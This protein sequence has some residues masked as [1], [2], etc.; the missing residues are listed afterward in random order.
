MTR[1]N[2]PTHWPVLGRRLIT[3]LLLLL[4]LPTT[5]YAQSADKIVTWQT[6]RGLP[7]FF[8]PAPELPMLDLR[9]T[10]AAG[11]ARDGELPGLAALTSRLLKSGTQDLD[12]QALAQRFEDLGASFSSSAG[13]DMAYVHLRSLT[14]T[15]LLDPALLTLTQVL[16]APHMPQA[17]LSR[18][19]ARTRQGLQ[20]RQQSPSAVASD[21][22]YQQLYQ[23][24]PYALG[25]KAT[26]AS[27][28][29]IQRQQ[30]VDFYRRYYVRDNAA[31]I[32][33]GAISQA[34]ARAIARRV[35]GALGSGQAAT[36]TPLAT[37]AP[38]PSEAQHITHPSN[39]T[40]ILYGMLSLPRQ[41]PD[42]YALYVGNHILGGSGLNSRISQAI[43]QERGLA[44]SAYSYMQ[45]LAGRGLFLINLQT[46][47]DQAAE[48]IA[49]LEATY[50]EFAQQGPTAEELTAAKQNIGGGFV[51][52]SASN[53][54]LLS[55]L[56]RIAFLGLP[57]AYMDTFVEQINQVTADEIKAAWQRQYGQQH[58][59]LVTAGPTSPHE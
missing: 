38:Q 29:R 18:E 2:H 22:F 8:Y 26:L 52:A 45:P 12:T 44:Y 59:V 33:V 39:Q 48:A 23:Q 28:Q 16:A 54:Q 21:A 30:L 49:V 25:G 14:R 31:L 5:L 24:H 6:E 7:V 11:S 3:G 15:A 36:T 37:A 4:S 58:P 34:Q 9:L 35:D 10:F 46:R 27:L 42:F 20:R 17:D 40:H 50:T 32:L 51:L 55:N 1:L 19:I 43:R 57:L 13:L 47:A 41:H 56:A 53:S